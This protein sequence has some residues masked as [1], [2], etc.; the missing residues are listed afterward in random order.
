MVK[1][2]TLEMWPRSFLAMDD[3]LKSSS[4]QLKVVLVEEQGR[5]FFS[6]EFAQMHLN[7][8]DHEEANAS[9]QMK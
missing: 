5:S 2:E 8:S 3:C 4:L 7:H 1:R 9:G 6:L